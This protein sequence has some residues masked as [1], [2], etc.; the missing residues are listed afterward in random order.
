MFSN[1]YII[2]YFTLKE[3]RL[4]RS[5]IVLSALADCIDLIRVYYDNL[6]EKVFVHLNKIKN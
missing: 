3:I 2:F 6:Q 4:Q 5:D 1:I